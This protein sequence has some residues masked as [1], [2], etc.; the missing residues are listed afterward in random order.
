MSHA[1]AHHSVKVFS[2]SKGQSAVASAA[3]RVGAKITDE[4]T[5]T[6]HDYRAKKSGV[7]FVANIGWPEDDVAGLW[8]A[9]EAAEKRKNSTVARESTLAIPAELNEQE[10]AKLAR[11]YALWLRDQYKVAATVAVHKPGR[12]GNKNNYHAHIQ[13]STREV[14]EEGNF[15]AKTRILDE[16]KTGAVEI[17]KMR[18]QW[19]KRCNAMLEKKGVKNRVD[20]RSHKRR[21]EE[22]G[23]PELPSIPHLGKDAMAVVRRASRAR[24]RGEKPEDVRVVGV[25]LGLQAQQRDLRNS[26]SDVKRTKRQEAKAEMEDAWESAQEPAEKPAQPLG[27]THDAEKRKKAMDEALERLRG[28]TAP[29]E[30]EDEPQPPKRRNRQRGRDRSR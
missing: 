5:G 16:R 29:I 26:W 25:V 13:Y 2:R 9:A 27:P 4:R 14:D 17:E 15:G 1:A 3:Y 21:A 19:A 23:G 28:P 24:A 30:F 10:R 18:Q 11:G 20:P 12:D 6:I 22:D 8:N 7:E